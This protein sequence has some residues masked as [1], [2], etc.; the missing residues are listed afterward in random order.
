MRQAAFPA[1]DFRL[2]R[3]YVII[4]SC[5][6]YMRCKM[7]RTQI[8]LTEAQAIPFHAHQFI[9]VLEF[10]GKFITAILKGLFYVAGQSIPTGFNCL[11]NHN[12]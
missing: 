9:A 6:A 1:L 2:D 5:Y 10:N 3:H 11:G 4:V 12:V 8:Q 7:V